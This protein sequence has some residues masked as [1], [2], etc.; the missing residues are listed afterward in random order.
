[1]TVY[2]SVVGARFDICSNTAHKFNFPS[3]LEECMMTFNSIKRRESYPW[4]TASVVPRL[5]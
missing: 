1:M 4:E 3:E 5:S 2:I